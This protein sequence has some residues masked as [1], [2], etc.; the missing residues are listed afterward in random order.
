MFNLHKAYQLNPEMELE[1]FNLDQEVLSPAQNTALART[2][3]AFG[4]DV[5]AI[6]DHRPH[7]VQL[8]Q[9]L[10]LLYQGKKKPKI[11]FH[12]FGDFTLYYP[13]WERMVSPLEGFQVEF[14]VASDR[15]K[16]LMDKMLLSNPTVVCPFPVNPEEFFPDQNLRSQQRQDWGLTDQDMVFLFTGRLSRQKRIKTL[17]ASFASEFENDS[18]AHLY[19]YGGQDNIGDPFL[20]IADLEGEY[21]RIFY[22]AYKALP[23]QLQKRIHFMG[24][25]PNADLLKVYQ[26]ADVFMNLSVHNDEDYGMSVAEAQFTGLPIGLTDWGGLASFHHPE[27]P[28]A[29]SFIPVKIGVRSKQISITQ[30]RK[31][32]RNYFS[33]PQRDN[34]KH[35]AKA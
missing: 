32:L 12:I 33:N 30:V 5:L 22:H 6:L 11:V 27:L 18:H 24:S 34:R 20:G 14:L 10:S 2:I 21:F 23:L 15:Q 8:I 31:T 28:Q 7:P 19:L 16:V 29:T 17:I 26:G 3:H 1:N 4:P 13:L 25:V 9:A 35:I